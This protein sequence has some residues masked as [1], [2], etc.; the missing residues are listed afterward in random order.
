MMTYYVV[1]CSAV[2]AFE[3]DFILAEIARNYTVLFLFLSN[4]QQ[5][6]T[7]FTNLRNL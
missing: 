3:S 1:F 7:K 6:Y 2:L 4:K 5:P